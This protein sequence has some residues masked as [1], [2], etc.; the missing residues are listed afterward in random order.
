MVSKKTDNKVHQL[1]KD[2]ISEIEADDFETIYTDAEDSEGDWDIISGFTRTLLRAQIDPLG[3]NSNLSF[4]PKSYL[5]RSVEIFSIE[6]P[7]RIQFIGKNAFCSSNLKQ[8]EFED[9]SSCTTLGF[10][11]FAE[12]HLESIYIPDSVKSIHTSAFSGCWKL[13]KVSLPSS[14]QQIQYAAFE[15]CP[16]LTQIEYRGTM[17]EFENVDTSCFRENRHSVKKVICTDGVI[18]L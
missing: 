10:N 14:I 11:S 18:D 4:V 13:S 2:Y 16:R 17:S 7:S 6:I 3:P 8:V 15:E 1:I 12:T 9:N 5:E